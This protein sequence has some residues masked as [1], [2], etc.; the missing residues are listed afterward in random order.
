VDAVVDFMVLPPEADS[1]LRICWGAEL[2]GVFRDDYRMLASDVVDVGFVPAAPLSG[3]LASVVW[4]GSYAGSPAVAKLSPAGAHLAGQVAA[5]RL[6]GERVSPPVFAVGDRWAVFEHGGTPLPAGPRTIRSLREQIAVV[7]A[8]AVTPPDRALFESVFDR[9]EQ[10]MQV[11]ES[12]P[13]TVRFFDGDLSPLRRTVEQ[14]PGRD[15]SVGV[16]QHGDLH[17][18]NWLVGA[19]GRLRVI[20]PDPLVGPAECDL[21]RW[22]IGGGPLFLERRLRLVGDVPS[23]TAGWLRFL[24]R[25]RAGALVHHGKDPTVMRA[26]I[27]AADRAAASIVNRPD[28]RF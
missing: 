17:D 7:A 26:L 18:R 16:V 13:T 25:E 4:S 21:A 8:V 2:A 23:A 27:A 24:A 22:L 19:D 15:G 10:L 6:W 12:R 9:A 14:L 20:D 3:G 5:V 1:L 28:V 11:A